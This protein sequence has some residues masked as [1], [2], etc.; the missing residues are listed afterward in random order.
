MAAGTVLVLDT[1]QSLRSLARLP[2]LM[3]RTG[4]DAGLVELV[5]ELLERWASLSIE[6]R[7]ALAR[8]LLARTN[9]AMSSQTL[10]DVGD[11]DLYRQLR[12]LL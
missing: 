9:P 10:A 2:A 4:L 3:A 11:A 12:A 7:D 8:A 6:R 5:N 1:T